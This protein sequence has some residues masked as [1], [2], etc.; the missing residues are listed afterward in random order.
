[1]DTIATLR[2]ELPFLTSEAGRAAA[3]RH[4]EKRKDNPEFR[5]AQ[6]E[7]SRQWRLANPDRVRR[8]AVPAQRRLAAE[9]AAI[10]KGNQPDVY[11]PQPRIRSSKFVYLVGDVQA[12]PR[13]QRRH[14]ARGKGEKHSSKEDT[15]DQPQECRPPT[16]TSPP[17]P[18]A[19]SCP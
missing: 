19:P 9:L 7:R 3:K 15:T 5:A 17:A 4:H 18:S 6:A 14:K 16:A 1:M 11:A 10:A 12:K 2:R 8:R 13:K